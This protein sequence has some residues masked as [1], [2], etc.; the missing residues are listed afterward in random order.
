[1]SPSPDVCVFRRFHILE[2]GQIAAAIELQKLKVFQLQGGRG[3][4]EDPLASPSTLLGELSPQSPVVHSGFLQ[5]RG[6]WKKSG[7]LCCQG[8]VREKYYF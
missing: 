8:K 6:N 4:G 1:M 3:L 5:V 7:N 2:N